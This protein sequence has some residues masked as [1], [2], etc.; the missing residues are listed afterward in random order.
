MIDCPITRLPLEKLY[1]YV[2]RSIKDKVDND[3]SFDINA[4]MD[5]FFEKSVKNSDRENAAKWTQSLPRVINMI[6]NDSFT[7][8]VNLIKGLDGIYGLMAD[9][10]KPGAEGFNNV[11]ARYRAEAPEDLGPEAGQQLLLEFSETQEEPGEPEEQPKPSVKKVNRLKTSVVQSGTLPVFMPVAP[12]EKTQDYVEKLDVP[13]ARIATNLSTLADALAM[14]D[15]FGEFIYQGKKL[16]ITATNLYAFS[17]SYFN[18]LDPTTQTEVKDSY[19]LTV[20]GVAKDTVTQ[21]D[22]RVIMVVTDEYGTNLYF[23]KDGNIT[24]KQN[25]KLAYQ[26]MRDVRK[27]GSEYTVTDIYGIEEQLMPVEVYA[28]ETYDEDIDGDFET[29]LEEVKKDRKKEL[30][31]LYELREKALSNDV[32]LDFVGVSKGV[33]SDLTA[34]KIPLSTFLS[35]PGANK[36]TLKS[37]YTLAKAKGNFRAGRSLIE[38]NGTE[39]LVNR[40]TMPKEVADQIAA[41]M[42]DVNIPFETKLDFYSQFIPEDA[43]TKMAYTMRKHEI[44]PD[45]NK[46]SFKINI[47]DKVGT[48]NGFVVEPRL[49]IPISETSLAKST[50]E[51]IQKGIQILSDVLMSG[52]KSGKPTFITYKSELLNS[53]E[54]LT[55]NTSTKQLGLGNYINFLTT[56]DGEIDIIDAD[57]GFYNKHLLFSEPTELSKKAV[58]T[59]EQELLEARAETEANKSS[60]QKEY[61]RIVEYAL[62][63]EYKE[64]LKSQGTT[65]K[66]DS[67]FVTSYFINQLNTNINNYDRETA[68]ELLN[69]FTSSNHVAEKQ[70]DMVRDNIDRAFPLGD[71]Q[72]ARK[73]EII[74]KTIEPEMPNPTTGVEPEKK[75]LLSR[76]PKKFLDRK[77]YIADEIGEAD[78]AKVLDWWD[79][80]KLG[81]ELQKHIQLEHAYNL[82]NSDIFAKFIVS[83][84]VLSNPDIK[85]QINPAKGTLV[86]IYHEAWHAFSQLYLTRKQKYALYDEVKNYKDAKGNQ[87]Y[88]SMD[89]EAI[90]ELLAE[91]FRT[92]MKNNYVK[93]GSPMRNS[94]FRK[95]MNFLR[96][97]FGKKPANHT[98]VVID[99]MNVPAVREMFEN[100]NYSS[101]KKA[102]VRSYTA[103]IQNIDFFELERGIAKVTKP[104][105]SVLGK[106]DSDAVSN[107]MDSAISEIIDDIYKERIAAGE[108]EGV[109]SGTTE[110]LLDPEY[111]AFT[112]EVVKEKL[113]ERLDYYK[114][115]L[116]KE[117]GIVPFSKIAKLESDNLEEPTIKSE[118]VAVLTDV[119]GEHK[120]VF[121]QSQIDGFDNLEPN[122]KKGTR[123]RGESYYGIKIVGDFYTHNSI[124]EGEEPVKIIVVSNIE[125]AQTQFDNYIAGGAKKYIGEGASVEIKDVPEYSLT[126]EQEFTLDNVRILKAALDNYGDPEWE[127]KGEKPS[128]TIAYHLE[129]SDFEISKTKYYLDKTELD[130]NGDEIDED[131]ENETHDSETS[132]EDRKPGKKSILQLASK[133]VVYALKSL[134]KVN[135]EGQASYDRFGFKEKADFRKLWGIVTN[136]IGGV[137][138]RVEAYELLKAESKNFPELKQLIEYK[139]PDPRKIKSRFEQTLSNSF[140]QTFAKPSI[141]YYQFT[142]FPQYQETMN[143]FGETD[144]VIS[145]FESDVTE[146]SLAVDST[147]RKFEALFKS[148][149][150]SRY[151]I[152]NEKNQAFLNIVNTTS[153]FE[154]VKNRGELDINK[155]MAFAAALGIKLDALPAIEKGLKDKSI[156]YG[157]PYIYD[158]VKDFNDISNNPNSTEEQ[159]EYL[160]KFLNNPI[161]TLR[162]EIPKGV[163]KSFKKE[164]AEKNILKRIAELQIKYGYENANPGVLLPDGNM[165]Y[166]NVNHSQ[167]TVTVNYLNKVDKLSDLWTD[168]KYQSMSHLR[169]GVSFFTLRS[170]V[171]G[172][173]FDTTDE[174]TDFDRKGDRSLQLLMPAGTQFA[175][176]KGINTADLDKTGK[177]FQDIHTF[178]LGGVAEFI[179]HAD[180]KSTFGIK[181]LGG[182]MKVVTNGL[183]NGVDPNLYIDLNKFK[184]SVKPLSDGEVVAVG[185]YFLDY[186]AVEFDRIRYFKQNPN[187]LLTIEGYNRKITTTKSGKIV[188]AGELF[189][190]FDNIL[191]KAT[192]NKLYKLAS[193]PAI[194]LPTHIRNDQDLFIDIQKDITRYFENKTKKL[195]DDEFS[196]FNYLDKKVYEKAGYPDIKDAAKEQANFD[197]IKGFLYNDWIHK[198][199]MFNL[200]NGDLAQ[201]DHDKEAVTKRAPGSTSDG[202]PMLNDEYM[203]TFI[204][205]IFNKN[206]YAKKLA[207]ETGRDLDK[208]VMDGTLNTGVIGDAKRTSIYLPEMLEGWEEKYRKDLA[209][210]IT[211]PKKLEAE[212]KRRLAKDRKAYEGM[213]ESDGAAVVTFDAYRTLRFMNNKWSTALEELY[214]KIVA[215]EEVDGKK[216]KEF[217]SVYKLHYYGALANAPI[218]TT[219]MHKFAVTPIIPTVA[220]PGTVM[221]DL[222]LKMLESNKQ[223]LTFKSG[224]KVASLNTDGETDDIFMPGSDYKAINPDAE[225]RNNQIYIDYLKE[226]TSVATKLKNEISYPT[227]KRVLLLDGLFNVGEIINTANKDIVNGYLSAVNNYSE[228]LGTELLNKIGYEYNPKTKEYTGDVSKFIELIRGELEAREIPDQLITILDS[229]ENGDLTMDFSIHPKADVLEKV[230]VNRIQKSVVKQKTKGE[231]LVQAPSTFY[232]GIWDSGFEM[233]KDPEEIKKLLG[234]NNLPFYVRGAL[235]KDGSRQPTNAMKVALALNGDFLNLL[236]LKHPD[237]EKIGN[238]NRLNALIQD[239]AWLKENREL[240]TITGPRI[241]TDAA[242]SME[243]AEVWHFLDASVGNTVI[244]PSEIVAKAGSDFDVDKIFFMLPHITSDGALVSAPAETLDELKALVEKANKATKKQRQ[245]KGFRGAQSLINQYKAYSQNQLIKSTKEIL[246]LPDNFASLTK[247]NNTYLIEDEVEFYDEY[248]TGYNSKINEHG[249]PVRRDFKDEKDVNSPSRSFDYDFNLN[250]FEE[251]LSGN[252]PLGILAKKNKTHTL[253]KS[254]GALMPASYKATIWNDA[255]KKY[256]ELDAAYDVVM[257]IKHQTT[258][259]KKGEE[260]VS[261]SN[262]NNVDGEKIGDILSHGLQGILDRANNSFPFKLKIIKEALPI[263]NHLIEAG[264]SVP[265]VFAFINN[266]WISDYID[267]QIL[268]SGSTALLLTE[269]VQPTQVRSTAA[270]MTIQKMVE[271]GGDDYVKQLS[272]YANDRRLQDLV[273]QLRKDDPNKKYVF[274]LIVDGEISNLAQASGER[275]FNSKDFPLDQIYSLYEYTPGSVNQEKLLFKRSAGIA[276]NDNFYYAG[277]AAWTRAFGDE[278][279]QLSEKQLK[280]LIKDGLNPNIA[281]LA[282]LMRMIQLEKQF[283]GMDALEM[284]FSPDTG[285]MDTTLQVKRRDDALAILSEVSKVDSDFLD[286]LRNNSIL[287][288]F[289]KSDMILK[290]TEPLF[291]LRLNKEIS[292]YLN[293]TITQNK[294]T[295]SQ[296]YGAGISGQENFTNAFNNAVVNYIYQNTMSNFPDANGQPVLLPES[297]HSLPIEKVEV[298]PAVTLTDKGFKVNI[299]KAEQDYINNVFLA[300]NNTTEGYISRN[301]EAF[302]P[303]ENPF[304]TFASYLKFAIEKAYLRDVYKEETESFITQK[305]LL[306]TFNRA[307]IMGTTKYSYTDLVMNTISEFEGQNIKINYPVLSQLSPARFE[308]DVNVLEL[309]DKGTAKGEVGLAYSKNL[310]QLGDPSIRKVRSSDKAKEKADNKKISDVFKN[311]SLMMF[312]QHGMGYSRLG[313]TDVLD[314][315]GFTSVMK[316]A[317]AAFIENNISDNTL[318]VIYNKLMV[319]KSAYKN[320]LTSP[321]DY[322]EPVVTDQEI[323]DDILGDNEFFQQNFGTGSV[324]PSTINIYDGTGEN[325]E[326]SNFAIRPFVFN[327]DSFKSVE[328]AF[329]FI[330]AQYGEYNQ[331]LSDKIIE[332]TNGATLRT[333]GKSVK[334]LDTKTWDSLS[335]K[336][337]KDLLKTS[338][339]QNPEALAKL[340]ATGNATLTHQYKGVEQ[341]KGRFSKV[342]MEVRNE[343]RPT[344]PSTQNQPTDLSTYT[345]HSGGAYGGDTFWDIIGREYG[346]TDQRH[347]KDAGNANLSQKLRNA[348]VQATIL[349]KEQM[350]KAR[351]EVERLLGENYPDTLQGNLQVRN[352]YQVANAD[353]VFAVATINPTTS[354]AVLGGT[355]TAVQ[356]GIKMGKPVYVFDLDTKKWYTQ[357]LDFLA[358]GFDK[359]KHEWNYNGWLEIDTPTLTKNFAGVGSRDIESYNVQKEGKWVP[360]EQYKGPE[361]EAAAKQAIRD[362]YENTLNQFVEP[363]AQTE[364]V[365]NGVEVQPGLEVYKGAL[366]EQEQKE[367]YEFGK[368]ILE[369]HGYNPFPQYVMASAGQFEWSPELVADKTGKAFNRGANYNKNI[370]SQKAI[371]KGS[372]GSGRWGYRYYTTNLDGSKIEP[373]PQN[374]INILQKVTGQDM[375]DYDTVLINLYPSGRTLG[376]HTDVTEDHRAL[377]RDIVSVSIGANAD[378]TFANTPKDW[379]SGDPSNSY[380]LGKINLSSGDI[381]QFG[382]PSRLI[383][384]TVTNVNGKTDLGPINLSNSNVNSG[385]KGG[386]LLNDDWRLNFTFRVADVNNSKGKRSV[387]QENMKSVMNSSTEAISDFYNGLTEEQKNK[388]GNLDALIEEYEDIPFDQ[389]VEDY[390]ETLKCKL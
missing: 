260:V 301:E 125:D 233:L 129:N 124:K 181:Q 85:I 379:I 75:S 106:L 283:S 315:E 64:L 360:R 88:I 226:V 121:L 219:A 239:E 72:A 143:I 10:S 11:L 196:K 21:S 235:N 326:L 17:N 95:I 150:G 224:S 321:S 134:H 57:P 356:L 20:K 354:P 390:I 103:N 39:F 225:I 51:Q 210:V 230:I 221:Y 232:N 370:I 227:Q 314:P 52:Q 316:P 299:N 108:T 35:I 333:L 152:R 188:R 374:I 41:V 330:K 206:T 5:D 268:L 281:G 13:R 202:D 145:G 130:E 115:K 32:I 285:L 105:D 318:N 381:V 385:F 175:N 294:E 380:K 245:Q 200:I 182:K 33:S 141:K 62:S 307:Y 350:D 335:S 92:Y 104:S 296:R 192:K 102:F 267:N 101:N 165:V 337:M 193:D 8:K 171:L 263:M 73:I 156:Y 319:E 250:K 109:R 278:N 229:Y 66:Y 309:N 199:E 243:F 253:F 205:N 173:M 386:L 378:F 154:D 86:D 297:V 352:Y 290:L 77:G 231:A 276:N 180:K 375:S 28:E 287:S 186:I 289:Y 262:E 236:N 208:F 365:S 139:F 87:P 366:T 14:S 99:V 242:N 160:L 55:Y 241:P 23:D 60:I 302:M 179:R 149:P 168:K 240:I 15:P 203:H 187:D 327:G 295:I 346:V 44:I 61:E 132:F 96:S 1:K 291:A 369:K 317:S 83:G 201:F 4:F 161:Q 164:V 388:L 272:S 343:L 126:P 94:L 45:M 344:Q 25:G 359:T 170:K 176:I 223:Y 84:S 163:L 31:K 234:S 89:Y 244:V 261:L 275:I 136:A 286:R 80:T 111:R 300:N 238:R 50:P 128:G 43:K 120:Y 325:A 265:E 383:S 100:L 107:T 348:G 185:G 67:Y 320:Y 251:M 76:L 377:D 189:T 213:I 336:L 280:D 328:Q 371:V 292:D 79:N 256:D 123:V 277:Q 114:S 81:K 155:S 214:Q 191:T 311:F 22:K 258:T 313:F 266:P 46:R 116:H 91:D 237:G 24:D 247:P 54:Y 340:L 138:D 34:T 162:G 27:N 264:G 133:E 324:K 140:W 271:L 78:T 308:K 248:A 190:A 254:L 184:T 194:D 338:F 284:A 74:Q 323:L 372:D 146:S 209:N 131:Q 19:A 157:L 151:I 257:P 364:E 220:V 207:K 135:R 53:E 270:R 303:S 68:L 288:S 341:D 222:H 204:N 169:P 362:V 65:A 332:T 137:R 3:K 215:G 274:E 298:G 183:T 63:P 2:Y 198:F 329:Q 122:I 69:M 361:V 37:I 353:A 93:K 382:G 331:E 82:V 282:M 26:F 197:V 144:T 358:N 347:Y 177:L 40:S 98:E 228:I 118:A 363:V 293:R 373:I 195:L 174:N 273:D 304:P 112:Y 255:T 217:F 312:Y 70:Y 38:L 384:H 368:S 159:K 90:D 305:A 339:E 345:N 357:D 178:T 246:S 367:F 148:S 342:L 42:F 355:N 158:V 119:N 259:N 71:Q 6:V 117:P 167:V 153:D 252:L 212:V 269:N 387:S 16:K 249:E 127:L 29:Y 349:T 306:D 310:K 48:G 279:A 12:S 218:A 334:N 59:F 47:Y 36:K 49:K 58:K 216:I 18:E 351:I 56:L 389:A 211:D 110:M 9:F 30:K 166:E 172:A 113:T 97:L 147:I 376:W 142:V 7:N 322:A